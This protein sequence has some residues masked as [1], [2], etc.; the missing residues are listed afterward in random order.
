L[1]LKLVNRRG[2]DCPSMSNAMAFLAPHNSLDSPP[3]R[4]FVAR[5]SSP[6]LAFAPMSEPRQERTYPFHI[7]Y[8]RDNG[9]NNSTALLKLDCRHLHIPRISL[10]QKVDK[11]ARGTLAFSSANE[12]NR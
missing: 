6:P 10:P 5:Q 1:P 7:P 2:S 11:R 8:S 3:R 9:V 4:S 12:R